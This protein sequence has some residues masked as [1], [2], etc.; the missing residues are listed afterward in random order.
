MAV[1][2][3]T[4]LALAHVLTHEVPLVVLGVVAICKACRRH[5]CKGHDTDG[6]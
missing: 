4:G 5:W 6:A 1:E 2:I 3:V